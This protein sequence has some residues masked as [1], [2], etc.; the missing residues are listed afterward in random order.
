ML[1]YH[2]LGDEQ[3]HATLATALGGA[4]SSALPS[5]AAA[6]AGVP[7]RTLLPRATYAA[8]AF[9]LL[10]WLA[11]G[12]RGVPDKGRGQQAAYAAAN[13]QLLLLPVLLQISAPSSALVI[14]V[15]VLEVVCVT[16]LLALASARRGVALLE[17]AALAAALQSQ[18]FFVGGHLCE[19]AGLHYPAGACGQ[20]VSLVFLE[21][22]RAAQAHD[23]GGSLCSP[24]RLCG[25]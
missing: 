10:L 19:F 21:W 12:L 4:A 20:A 16:K 18:M 9:G 15:G 1:G 8:C 22:P 7:L 24:R 14:L 25:L 6:L 17:W 11:A 2:A 13:L 3:S 5:W 23:D